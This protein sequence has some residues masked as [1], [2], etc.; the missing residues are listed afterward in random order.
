LIAWTK[1]QDPTICCLQNIHLTD[2]HKLKVKEREKIFQE[3]VTPK[4]AEVA[5]FISQK[6][7][8]N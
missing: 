3:N 6:Q 5:I 2:K 4:Q 1:K 8:S 7:T